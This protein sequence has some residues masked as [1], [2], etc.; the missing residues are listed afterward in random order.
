MKFKKF[1]KKRAISLL[2]S[3]SLALTACA[4][5][6][7]TAS[8][9]GEETLW[10]DT[11]DSYE[12]VDV[13][14]TTDTE[15]SLLVSG[16]Y[17]VKTYEGIKG[18]TLTTTGR[19]K[20]DDSSYYRVDTRA[21]DA[22]N[23]Y[24]TT[25]VSRFSTQNRGG[26][27][28]FNDTYTAEAGKDIVLAFKAM[29]VNDGN[30]TYADAFD[31]GDGTTQAMVDFSNVEKGTWV[32]VKVVVTTSGTSVYIGDSTTP[33]ST[34]SAT[35]IST[36]DF[37]AYN[38]TSRDQGDAQKSATN[39][40]G[41]P[42]F[43]LDDVVVYSAP[44]GL[45]STV[46]DANGQEVEEVKYVYAPTGKAPEGLGLVAKD[47]FDVA[48]IDRYILTGSAPLTYSE[49]KS[50]LLS[51]GANADARGESN[52]S[53]TNNA[54]AEAGVT[55][56]YITAKNGEGSQANR[57]PK[58]TFMGSVDADGN[59]VPYEVAERETVV[60]QFATRLHAG[61]DN[62]TQP[63]EL[64]FSGDLV[65]SESKGNIAS[66]L[67]MITTN[68]EA[69]SGVYACDQPLKKGD[70]TVLQV[71]DNEW[72]LVT[73]KAY[74]SE[75]K[76][77]TASIAVTK[78]AGEENEETV[79]ILGNETDMV[80]I[81][82]SSKS[83]V[84]NLPYVSFRSGNSTDYGAS[85]SQ[86]DIDNVAI[87]SSNKPVVVEDEAITA[88]I[89]SATSITSDAD[90]ETAIIAKLTQNEDG[91]FAVEVQKGIKAGENTIE[92]KNAPKSKDKIMVLRGSQSM[93][94]AAQKAF[95]VE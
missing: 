36:M 61:A 2:C 33:V 88:T 65:A 38:G 4:S 79:Y 12:N 51:V 43:S 23:K 81:Q 10:S 19:D 93:A 59:I 8:A 37:S 7:I 83:G 29:E 62:T 53:G 34:S 58:L 46:P 94:P 41:Y 60:V 71:E 44:D 89:A 55:D 82:N 16:T 32:N 52:W 57:G 85:G 54:K 18:V 31:V 47:N 14:Y 76:T 3:A 74:R 40:S 50:V 70:T 39:P 45:N 42:T 17:G 87:Y 49:F 75:G 9:A 91:T 48:T 22:T 80:G 73:M 69:E 1:S 6:M 95:I 66:P 84:N 13:M 56:H 35:S 24:L 90:S 64:I 68:A 72:V 5:F 20:G 28:K 27:F 15:P 11:F 77:V 78:N 30:T 26:K 86:N 67:A 63:A 25:Q 92:W 21:D